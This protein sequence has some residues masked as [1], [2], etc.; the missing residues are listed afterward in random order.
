MSDQHSGSSGS[1]RKQGHG[2]VAGNG[3]HDCPAGFPVKGNASS[4]LAH[5][6]GGR[7][8]DATIPEVCFATPEDAE[9]D[10]YR[11]TGAASERT[12]IRGDG[13]HACPEGFPIK[14]N[15]SSMIAHS[16]ESRYF[17][18][19]IPEVCFATAEAAQSQGYRISGHSAEEPHASGPNA[20]VEQSPSQPPPSSSAAIAAQNLETT[21]DIA[22]GSGEI[23]E[24]LVESSAE[25]AIDGGHSNQPRT[26]LAA[27]VSGASEAQT[28]APAPGPDQGPHA[29]PA[30]AVVDKPNPNPSSAVSAAPA[31]PGVKRR[32][33]RHDGS[34]DCPAD[35][36][37]KGI[38]RT[39]M[40]VGPTDAGYNA[41]MPDI[42]FQTLSDAI[43]DGYRSVSN[44][45]TA[46]PPA[47]APRNEPEPST[48]IIVRVRRW[49]VK[50]KSSGG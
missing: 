4:K 31:Q 9:D 46:R 39:R 47:A 37:I 50:R 24:T 28:T 32:S 43:E 14:G 7:W 36:P 1:G 27:E 40:A 25:P 41:T 3:T 19:T 38:E 22:E 20:R 29:S 35:F 48:T 6:P 33:I 23:P 42:C 49:W 10:G 17:N 12:W 34:L 21:A 13:S 15:R 11:V 45:P 26:D 5:L 30:R 2:F 16:P 44:P 18:S 8:Y